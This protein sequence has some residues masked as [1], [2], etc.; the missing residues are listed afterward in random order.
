LS[1]DAE[2]QAI[3]DALNGLRGPSPETAPVAQMRAGHD[4]ETTQLAGEGPDVATEDA[5][6]AGV[7]ARIY[8]PPDARGTVA[9]FH[10]GGWVV[11]KPRSTEA[12]CR[13]LAL[14]SGA[15][16]AN[17]DY[18]LAPEHP[19]PAGVEDAVAATRALRADVVAGDSAGANLAAV[20]A[21]KERSLKL[22][23]LVYPV[24]DAGLNTPSYREFAE[25][26]GLTATGMKRFWELYG[27][28]GLDPDASPLRATDLAGVAPAYVLLAT[29]DVLH[30]EGAAY[31]RA[32]ER[33]GVPVTVDERPAIHGFWRWQLTSALA[34]AAV[35]DAGAAIRAALA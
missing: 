34:R 15:T 21:R 33:A 31:A 13:A 27:A 6:L 32:L 25:G 17:V 7:P 20:V 16:V 22:Q 24:T 3:L 23:L 30:D 26:Y 9:Y 14:A 4:Q 18:R 29:H 19:F 28:D 35:E 11:G 5:D 12:V 2:I 10:G 8:T 1:L